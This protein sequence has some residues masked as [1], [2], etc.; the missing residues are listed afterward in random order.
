MHPT[1]KASRLRRTGII[2]PP[3]WASTG[4]SRREQQR[5]LQRFRIVQ[6][7]GQKCG[8]G[9]VRDP[10]RS[11]QH[12]DVHD[13]FRQDFSEARRAIQPESPR[14]QVGKAHR[15]T[16]GR[17]MY[18]MMASRWCLLMAQSQQWSPGGPKR[19]DN[20]HKAA[21]IA[22]KGRLGGTW[23]PVQ[24]VRNHGPKVIMQA[25]MKIAEDQG[26]RSGRRGDAGN[27][28]QLNVLVRHRPPKAPATPYC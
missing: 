3:A 16:R 14:Q 12:I 6:E 1:A 15:D 4:S 10:Q 24:C 7:T 22:S 8:E 13:H 2:Q 28:Q 17:T 21:G 9:I 20:H 18:H 5:W 26:A 25:T 23:P 19:I 11:R 27:A